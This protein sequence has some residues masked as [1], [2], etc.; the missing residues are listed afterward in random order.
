LGKP[1]S[2][3]HFLSPL[4]V[5]LAQDS[6]KST[7]LWV[8][9]VALW[10]DSHIVKLRLS[11]SDEVK[12]VFHHTS[13]AF[14]TFDRFGKRIRFVG[15][16]VIMDKII[17]HKVCIQ[18]FD[19][20]MIRD[21]A[22]RRVFESMQSAFLQECLD[23]YDKCCGEEFRSFTQKA[24]FWEKLV[25]LNMV[26]HPAVV[27]TR[28]S[29]FVHNTTKA[30]WYANKLLVTLALSAS[31]FYAT[32]A[33]RPLPE[34][35]PLH[36]F[37]QLEGDD[38]CAPVEHSL[39][40]QVIQSSVVYVVCLLAATVF[41]LLLVLSLT[42]RWVYRERW[43]QD[44][45]LIVQAMLKAKEG[46]IIALGM[47]V[48][49]FSATFTFV[50][51]AN[52]SEVD[53]LK[54]FLAASPCVAIMLFVGPV[55][56]AALALIFSEQIIHGDPGLIRQLRNVYCGNQYQ[57]D[58][59]AKET[60]TYCEQ[61]LQPIAEPA[62]PDSAADD[63]EEDTSKSPGDR[64]KDFMVKMASLDFIDDDQR[65]LER[66]ARLMAYVDKSKPETSL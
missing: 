28:F 40:Y 21:P 30:L 16:M 60:Q 44:H 58:E 48:C 5:G 54:W 51:L 10:C 11:Q 57:I 33:K 50:F 7:P 18:N 53:R 43:K 31:F 24:S 17:S 66:H 9:L 62:S 1:A 41:N 22:M 12:T 39:P 25:L 2:D 36:H 29:I 15:L 65:E 8:E 23:N 37:P 34:N 19:G 59:E 52:V 42:R 27:F 64:H 13:P 20:S 46:V 6:E 49:L 3:H 35:Y 26:C 14:A 63:V 4:T 55:S 32:G 45:K 47:L 38:P 61:I 56:E